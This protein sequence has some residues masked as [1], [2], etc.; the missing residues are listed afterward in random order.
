MTWSSG[1]LSVLLHALKR[2]RQSSID[3]LGYFGGWHDMRAYIALACLRCPFA[4]S[5]SGA[6]S[7]YCAMPSPSGRSSGLSAN[8]E[9]PLPASSTIL[10]SR[11]AVRRMVSLMSRKL[12]S[13]LP[14]TSTMMSSSRVVTAASRRPS[15]ST[16]RDTVSLACATA[17]SRICDSTSERI[18]KVTSSSA[19]PWLIASSARNFFV[20]RSSILA[21]SALSLETSGGRSRPRARRRGPSRRASTAPRA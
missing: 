5:P 7:S 10:N 21:L 1:T 12:C 18:L 11:R 14:G 20:K 8:D 4:S 6:I 9:L 16:R 13:L 2:P 15:S 19:G 17:R 3:S